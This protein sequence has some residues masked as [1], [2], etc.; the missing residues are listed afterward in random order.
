MYV[1]FVLGF[2]C[3]GEAAT[4][5]PAYLRKIYRTGPEYKLSQKWAI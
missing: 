1:L 4:L 5:H 3:G 2:V